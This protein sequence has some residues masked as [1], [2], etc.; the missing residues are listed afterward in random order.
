MYDIDLNRYTGVVDSAIALRPQIEKAVDEICAQDH[1]S[2]RAA[3]SQR[4]MHTGNAMA[5][6]TCMT[7]GSFGR[8]VSMD[9]EEKN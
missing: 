9:L 2:F 7:P 8:G 6:R 5:M 4:S 3:L 1:A